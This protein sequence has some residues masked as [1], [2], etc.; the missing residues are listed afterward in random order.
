[1]ATDPTPRDLELRVILDGKTIH[2]AR[3]TR[4][5]DV[6]SDAAPYDDP[7]RTSE[8]LVVFGIGVKIPVEGAVR[9]ILAL[10]TDPTCSPHVSFVQVN[11]HTQAGEHANPVYFMDCGG[12]SP[13]SP[14]GRI[15]QTVYDA[16]GRPIRH[17]E[18][19]GPH[20]SPP[21]PRR[22]KP[23]RPPDDPHIVE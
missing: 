17:I 21:P 7:I 12:F 16:Q 6:L 18:G 8:G 22:P 3:F 15:T 23:E 4:P 1:M 10:S 2:T 11:G 20:D 19:D 9:V 14:Q 13:S 5:A